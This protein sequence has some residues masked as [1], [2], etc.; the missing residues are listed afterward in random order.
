MVIHR[1]D[2][3]RPFVPNDHW[4][5]KDVKSSLLVAELERGKKSVQVRFSNLDCIHRNLREYLNNNITN[6]LK[7]SL[8][9]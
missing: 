8:N 7:D 2:C 9:K 4:L 5:V 6:I 3:R 1:R